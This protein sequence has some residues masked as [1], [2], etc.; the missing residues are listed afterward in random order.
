[1]KT[2]ETRILHR[3]SLR[4][5]GINIIDIIFKIKLHLRQI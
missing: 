3:L 2:D 4:D 5:Q 1:M